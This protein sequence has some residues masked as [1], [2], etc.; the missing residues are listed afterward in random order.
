[1]LKN[2]ARVRLAQYHPPRYAAMW[3]GIRVSDL[4]EHN[5]S[6]RT[7]AEAWRDRFNYRL[8]KWLAK[9]EYE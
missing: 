2:K 3:M 4:F 6:G 9:Q 7:T 8:E 1:M 5:K